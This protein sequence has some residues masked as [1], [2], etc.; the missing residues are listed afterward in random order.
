MVAQEEESI[1]GELRHRLREEFLQ[2]K[3]L[4][5]GFFFEQL[6][7]ILLQAEGDERL[8]LHADG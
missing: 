3:P 4:L 7:D 8:G 6:A 2:R 1:L 5:E